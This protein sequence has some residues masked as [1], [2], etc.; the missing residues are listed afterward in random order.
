M[1]PATAHSKPLNNRRVSM[2]H[3]AAMERSYRVFS[4]QIGVCD[5]R[6]FGVGSIEKDGLQSF[7]VG[8]RVEELLHPD[9]SQWPRR[10]K[11]GEPERTARTYRPIPLQSLGN[12]KVPL[13]HAF[14]SLMN[15]LC[16]A[17]AGEYVFLTCA[18]DLCCIRNRTLSTL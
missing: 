3:L 18:A 16:D 5:F 8:S 15:Q 13:E 1:M 2:L 17:G 6:D 4:R 9:F 7:E 10:A 12:T 11:R 14:K